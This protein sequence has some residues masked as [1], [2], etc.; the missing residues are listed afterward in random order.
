MLHSLPRK[1]ASLE[2]SLSATP[3]DEDVG[4]LSF[5]GTSSFIW[6]WVGPGERKAVITPCAKAKP[7]VTEWDVSIVYSEGGLSR[8]AASEQAPWALE[9]RPAQLEPHS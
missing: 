2:G 4:L 7:R 8:K 9:S 5:Q 1:G 3:A 6:Q